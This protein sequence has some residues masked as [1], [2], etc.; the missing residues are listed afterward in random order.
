MKALAR[1]YIWWPKMDTDIEPLVKKCTD[2]QQSS[3][4][5][6][7]APLHP[8]EWPAQPWIRLHLDFAGSFL[9]KMYLVLVDAHSK[10]L[11][12][13]IMNSI[14]S[15]MTTSRLCS[16]FATHGLPQQIVNDN[17]PTFTSEAFKEF[18]KL[19]GI[20]HTISSPY[21]PLSNGLAE[22][23]V[24]I[25]KQSLRQM[26]DGSL[27]EKISKFL[28]KYRITPHTTTGITS[29][30]LLMGRKLRSRLDLLQPSLTSI[31]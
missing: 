6:P 23:A 17:G 26:Q 16:I 4:S 11:D 2:C 24:Q 3:S 9:G 29:A 18:T 28:F 7:T 5:P 30:E 1:S 31:V 25:F 12:V 15:E 27:T 19:N 22:R 8:W 14:T 10:W 21:H 13:Q 20:K